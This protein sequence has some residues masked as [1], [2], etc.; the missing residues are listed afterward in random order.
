MLS[1][2]EDYDTWALI[3][4]TVE[5]DLQSF[6]NFYPDIKRMLTSI[7]QTGMLPDPISQRTDEFIT[8]QSNIVSSFLNLYNINETDYYAIIEYFQTIIE[9]CI[10]QF[11]TRIQ[12]ALSILES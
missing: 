9:F 12:I 7:S 4:T 8:M 11:K 5:D 3:I 6:I 10:S 1:P 2:E